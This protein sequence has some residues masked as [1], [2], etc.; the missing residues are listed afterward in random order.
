MPTQTYLER[1]K[2]LLLDHEV[3]VAFETVHGWIEDAGPTEDVSIRIGFGQLVE[4][5]DSQGRYIL[6][7]SQNGELAFYEDPYDFSINLTD[8]L[9]TGIKFDMLEDVI[10]P[11]EC[12]FSQEVLDI[13]I[14]QQALPLVPSPSEE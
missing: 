2:E 14:T 7:N 9:S 1:F 4:G 3:D 6:I 5:D 11:D 12:L 8:W 10:D 13:I